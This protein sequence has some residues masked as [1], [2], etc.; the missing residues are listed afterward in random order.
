[1]V[2]PPLCL[3]LSPEQ[4]PGHRRRR[5]PSSNRRRHSLSVR[6]GGKAAY[7]RPSGCRAVGPL[8]SGS[9]KRAPSE[10]PASRE[11]LVEVVPSTSNLPV[12]PNSSFPLPK[13]PAGF[14]IDALGKVVLASSR[15]MATIVDSTNNFPLEC[16]IRRI[17]ESSRGQEC[18]LLCPV[19]T[20]VQILKSTNFSGWAAVDDEEVEAILPAAAY[21][22]AKIHMHLVFSGF[23]YTARGRFCYSEDDILE[24]RTD[25]GEDIDGLPTEGI[26]ITCFHQDGTHYMIYT[27]SDPLLFVAVKDQDG[28][29]QIADDVLLDDPAVVGAIDEE[30]EFNALVE[31][32]AALLE[33]VLG[34][35]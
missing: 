11:P 9:S 16:V 34:E 18:M 8:S 6:G 13:P 35:R 7:Y 20:P 28:R 29:L 31:E 4:A 25:D 30:T 3:S 2:C 17:F 23:C 33:S 14:V 19:D 15:R 24:F 12:A 21:A 1:M 27:P 5:R 26:E 32:E 22:L 10:K